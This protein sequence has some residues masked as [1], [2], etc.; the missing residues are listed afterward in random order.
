MRIGDIASLSRLFEELIH[1]GG[2]D[3][4][5]SGPVCAAILSAILHA[6]QELRLESGEREARA[7]ESYQRCRRI[8]ESAAMRIRSLGDLSAEC[9]ISREYL[10]RLFHRFDGMSPYQRL[11]RARM[12]HAAARL[13]QPGIRVKDVATELGFSDP[14]HFSRTFQSCFKVPPSRFAVR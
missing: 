14:F 13:R 1:W 11:L 2:R 9:G 4:A 5:C 3:V 6:A 12:N 8:L 10:C 7:F